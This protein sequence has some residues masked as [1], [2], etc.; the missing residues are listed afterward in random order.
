M[1]APL[2]I[3]AFFAVPGLAV[4][5][6]PIEP[7]VDA[8]DPVSAEVQAQVLQALEEEVR[9][10]ATPPTL[11]DQASDRA[12]EVHQT[13]AF[14]KKGQQARAEAAN[15]AR[16]EARARG[17]ARAREA[18][19]RSNGHADRGLDQAGT[20]QGNADSNRAA[21][22]ARSEEARGNGPSELPRPNGR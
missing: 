16:D 1:R 3:L 10:P 6:E 19:T 22:R 12:R 4:A 8:K 7:R 11:P 18:S 2:L 20:A 15:A 17:L 14:G 9:V 13:T 21:G 5:R